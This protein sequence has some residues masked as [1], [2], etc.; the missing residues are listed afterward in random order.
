MR[1]A[2]VVLGALAGVV[3]LTWVA[4]GNEFFLYKVFAPA[5]E[6]VRRETFEQSKAYRQGMVQE[7]QNMQLEYTRGNAEQKAALRGVILHRA[8]NVDPSALTPD[9]LLFIGSLR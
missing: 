6:Q 8:A 7:L 1:Y 3:A 4:Q 9:L 2:A 5:K